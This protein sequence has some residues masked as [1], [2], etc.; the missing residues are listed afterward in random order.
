MKQLSDRDS[1]RDHIQ[2]LADKTTSSLTLQTWSL[3]LFLS[4]SLSSHFS[5]L[6]LVSYVKHS[7]KVKYGLNKYN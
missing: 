6:Q 4:L 2:F 3:P 1:N 7:E 5:N